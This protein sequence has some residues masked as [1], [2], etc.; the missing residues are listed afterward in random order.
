MSKLTIHGAVIDHSPDWSDFKKWLNGTYASFSHSW[1]EDDSTYTVIIQDSNLYRI[2]SFNKGT[3]EATDFETSW[4]TNKPVQKLDSSSRPVVVTEPRSGDDTVYTTHDFCDKCTWF[5]ESVRVVDKTITSGD[6]GTTWDTGDGYIIDMI[7]GRVQDD[8]GLVEEQKLLNP[9]DPHGYQVVVKIDGVLKTM[10][11][12]FEASGGDYEVL[13]EAGQ[14]R[15]FTPVTTGTVTA[16]YSKAAGSTF[17]L[18]PLPDKILSIERAKTDFS[19]NIV[20]LDGVEYSVWGYVWYFAKEYAEA[21]SLPLDMKIPLYTTKYKRMKQIQNEAEGSHPVLEFYGSTTEERAL[22][23]VEFRR[24]ARGLSS[25]VQS[26]YFRYS[27]T[28]DLNSLAGL[29][30]RVKTSHDRPLGGDLA[31]L[32]FYCT[33]RSAL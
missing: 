28:R 6:G 3:E 4:K 11:E 17:F 31:T 15:F 5:G 9:S 22:S 12:P 1:M 14:I 29:E 7:S 16:S 19:E 25:K 24:T 10:R 23:Q 2:C 18:K 20:M 27:T 8:D 32:T 30:L 33:S 13:W 21:N 26:I